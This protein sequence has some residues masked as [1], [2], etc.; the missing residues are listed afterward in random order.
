[1]APVSL[2]A[3]EMLVGRHPVRPWVS[4]RFEVT[5]TAQLFGTE[6]LRHPVRHLRDVTKLGSLDKDAL[7][8][9]GLEF[10]GRFHTSRRV[11][12][13]SLHAER[14]SAPNPKLPCPSQSE[15]EIVSRKATERVRT[16]AR[17]ETCGKE[18]EYRGVGRPRKFCGEGC[19]AVANN[20][21]R[22]VV[23]ATCTTRSAGLTWRI[24][25]R[26]GRCPRCGEGRIVLDVRPV[27]RAW[28]C[29]ER[30]SSSA[31]PRF[32]NPRRLRGSRP[33]PPRGS[34]CR[35]S[36]SASPLPGAICCSSSSSQAPSASGSKPEGHF[37]SEL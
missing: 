34:S 1:M 6:A 5:S 23:P 27:W 15:T 12:P 17:C 29:P 31:S 37:V 30:P 11:Q 33:E 26:G 2:R 19:Y 3:W 14:L 8:A 9:Q 22:R 36:E 24:R 18:L 32:R 16:A 28:L 35:Q 13:W 10:P 25:I 20:E 4:D 7:D 21:R